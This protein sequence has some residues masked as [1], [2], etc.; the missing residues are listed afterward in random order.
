SVL[1]VGCNAGEVTVAVAA[2]LGARRVVGIDIDPALVR[3]ARANLRAWGSTMREETGELDYFPVSCGKNIG[4]M[5]VILPSAEGDD[6]EDGKFPANVTFRASNFI[7]E[8]L[9]LSDAGRH[10]VVLALSV[11][12]WV[13]VNWGDAGLR[14]FFSKC[15]GHLRKGGRL[16]LEPQEW[17]EGYK[18]DRRD[19]LKET[20]AGEGLKVNEAEGAGPAEELKLRPDEFERYLIDSVGFR[21]CQKLGS[22]QSAV[23][24]FR[25]E[26]C[27]YTK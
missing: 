4:P 5:P 22:V 18:R 1:D 12:K 14:L 26:I 20:V 7:L 17:D 11:T 25:R 21:S 15:Y 10:D 13:H 8:P 2:V 23:K 16:V 19:V 3:R 27:V 6:D 9:P 24:G